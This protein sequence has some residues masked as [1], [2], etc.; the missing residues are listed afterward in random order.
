MTKPR[1]SVLFLFDP[2]HQSPVTPSC[3]LS[4]P[5][6]SASDKENDVPPGDVTVF[7]SR[8]FGTYKQQDAQP[9]TPKGKLI[10]FGDTPAPGRA[11]DEAEHDG[12]DADGELSENDGDVDADGGAILPRTPLAELSVEDTPRPQ[13]DAR[14]PL[15]AAVFSA[16]TSPPAPLRSLQ[17]T[18]P[19]SSPL[20]EVINSIN[21]GS[22]N[23]SR[24]SISTAERAAVL[25]RNVSEPVEG[26]RP[27][28]LF[29]EINVCAPETPVVTEFDLGNDEE[30]DEK[31][32]GSGSTLRPPGSLTQLS[33]DDP[34]RTSVDLYSSFH[35]QMQ[36]EDMSFDLL[37]DKISFLGNA[38]DSFWAAG[39]DAMFE[40]DERPVPALKVKHE[41]RMSFG[42]AP[43]ALFERAFS[44]PHEFHHDMEVPVVRSPTDVALHVPLPMSPPPSTPSPRVTPPHMQQQRLEAAPPSPP[45]SPV[46]LDEPSLLLE[47]EPLPPPMPA[48][49]PVPALRIV[50]KTFKVTGR[51]SIAPATGSG[52]SIS[53]PVAQPPKQEPVLRKTSPAP[54]QEAPAPAPIVA[55]Q[56]RPARPAIQ[57][58]QRPPPSMRG[59]GLIIGLPPQGSSHST[60]A[61]TSSNSSSSGSVSRAGG[62]PRAPPG[63]AA[64]S[65]R[66]AGIQ[67]PNL[68]LNERAAPRAPLVTRPPR[69]TVSATGGLSR[70]A[71]A[72]TAVPK[73]LTGA[74][75]LRPPSRVAAP[76]SSAGSTLPRPASRLP[77]P[78]FSGL[79]RHAS[80]GGLARPRAVTAPRAPA[81]G[82]F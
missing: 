41:K 6:L 38:Q 55:P 52:V 48:P 23:V 34:R 17:L 5:E 60:S 31:P 33:P 78:G 80:T 30:H 66:F 74:N 24:D 10:D 49:P 47:S 75:G 58:V 63:T 42:D 70:T 13:P 54:V 26:S 3:D 16:P 65:S 43:V 79:A 53:K 36:S 61:S 11:W 25:E 7:F 32:V 18:A 72:G 19:L 62:A 12:S 29:P 57:G 82:R 81:G 14:R 50:K 20:A 39:E 51:R 4:S 1:N 69:A 68:A 59:A 2:L 73:S 15:Q 35:L 27:S 45:T 22:T 21:M 44:V 37:N 67:R 77:G 8:N 40:F 56:P 46:S 71:S 76:G 64:P 9:R 28:S